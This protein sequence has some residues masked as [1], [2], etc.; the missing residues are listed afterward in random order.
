MKTK[1][2]LLILL[3]LITL[4]TQAQD[5]EKNSASPF[6]EVEGYAEKK[7]TPDEIYVTIVIKEREI[8]RDKISI[9][10]QELKLKQALQELN[11]SLERFFVADALSDYVR[12]N[13]FNK[14]TISEKKYELM[15]QNAE[16]V[17]SVFQ[18][19]DELKVHQAYIDRVDH[20]KREKFQEEVE[21]KAI[22]KAKKKADYL[23]N[24]IGQQT[25][26]A[27]IVKEQEF[28]DNRHFDGLNRRGSLGMLNQ[29]MYEKPKIDKASAYVSFKKITFDYK[30][31]A[32]FEIK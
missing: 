9:E 25:G 3:A 16:E 30:I 21:V 4:F 2:P 8:G 19:L 7:V 28:Q 12:V 32:K 26:S 27:L 5:I 29:V 17:K 18:K 14:E 20:S 1:Y 10:Q 15:L 13:W 22:Q 11:I 24:A 31:Y 6:I 23:L